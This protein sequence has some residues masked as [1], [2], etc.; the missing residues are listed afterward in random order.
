[1]FVDTTSALPTPAGVIYAFG[2]SSVL[3]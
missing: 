3:Q 1:M 2:G